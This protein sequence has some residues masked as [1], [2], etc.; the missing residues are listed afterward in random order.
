MKVDSTF[1]V[2][3]MSLFAINAGYSVIAPFFPL[4]FEEKSLSIS[5]NGIVLSLY[6]VCYM[7]LSPFVG[8]WMAYI[9]RKRTLQIGSS[10]LGC[11]FLCFAMLEFIS[12]S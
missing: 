10:V 3:L 5:Y 7:I 1:L 8:S 11:S 6:A 2:I 9:G 4:V 12:N